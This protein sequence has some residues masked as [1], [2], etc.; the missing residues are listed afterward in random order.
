M[1]KKITLL[2]GAVGTSLWAIAEKNGVEKDPV[3]TYNMEHP[4]FV[5]QLANEFMDAGAEIVLAN[6]FGANG[7]AVSRSPYS[8]KDVVSTGVKLAKQAR[9]TRNVKICLS[10]GPLPKLMEPYG[11]L[12]EDEV[13]KLYREQLSAGM[14][15]GPDMIL[16][17][18]FIDLE[19]MKVATRVAKEFGV[20]VFC[21]M[22]FLKVGK[23]LMGQ[24]VTDVIN[25]L[26]PMGIDAIGLNCSIG[27]ALAV[28][29]IREFHEKTKLPLIFKP[30]AGT[31]ISSLDGKTTIPYSPDMFVSEIRPVLDI[32]DYVGGC[33]GCDA[34]YVSV[35]RDELQGR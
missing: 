4:E 24:S 5:L 25:G 13:E 17:Q 6:T 14:E 18:T 8:V 23:T 22:S 9:G 29:V 19:M 32:V 7:I 31:P 20:P 15:Q 27:P 16:L 1:V 10:A 33:C 21:S 30:N 35:L 11:D 3:W 26:E 28:P 2:D 12:E 34:T